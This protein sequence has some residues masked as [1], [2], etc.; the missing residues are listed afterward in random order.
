MPQRAAN[1][2][3]GPE[4]GK[5]LPSNDRLI[6][7]GDGG[8]DDGPRSFCVICG[9][10][11]SLRSLFLVPAEPEP[12]A[13]NYHARHGRNSR[14]HL[15]QYKHSPNRRVYV[16]AENNWHHP[17]GLISPATNLQAFGARKLMQIPQ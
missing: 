9:P 6:D 7:P 13:A 4:A 11:R 15:H 1:N 10:L 17:F 2:A 3:N 14:P 16:F 8:R 5:A 12:G